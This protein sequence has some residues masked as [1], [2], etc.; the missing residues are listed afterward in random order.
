ME[1]LACKELSLLAAS[2]KYVFKVSY[3]NDKMTLL[4]RKFTVPPKHRK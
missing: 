1:D 2:Y 3:K 4:C